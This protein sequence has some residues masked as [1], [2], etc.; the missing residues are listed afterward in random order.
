MSD[1]E[2][3]G[4][5]EILGMIALTLAIAVLTLPMLHFTGI[6]GALLNISAQL[7]NLLFL[8]LGVPI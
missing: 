6:Y 8:T 5:S 4:L 2:K 1:K 7:T 3:S